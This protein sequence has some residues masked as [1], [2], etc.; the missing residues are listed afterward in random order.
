LIE[1]DQIAKLVCSRFFPDGIIQERLMSRH[2]K[3]SYI[4]R[5][6][7]NLCE[8]VQ[9]ITGYQRMFII[10][11]KKTEDGLIIL[12]ENS[13]TGASAPLLNELEVNL[14]KGSLK[15]AQKKLEKRKQQ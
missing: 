15:S 13:E 6:Q 14:L 3:R 8:G 5:R 11:K 4:K 10:R 12:L 2:E 1:T 7:L 9:H